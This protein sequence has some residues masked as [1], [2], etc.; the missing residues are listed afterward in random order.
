V[1]IA[2]YGF[3][4]YD[5]AA[6]SGTP[7]LFPPCLMPAKSYLICSAVGD[8]AQFSSH[9]R[10]IGLAHF[11]SLNNS[12]DELSLLDNH[13]QLLDRVA[14]QSSWYGKESSKGRSLERIDV[15]TICS[16]D[17]NWLPSKDSMGTT[18]GRVN[19]VEGE[20]VDDRP[21]KAKRVSYLNDSTL[22]LELNKSV[23]L[24]ALNNASFD[25]APSSLLPLSFHAANAAQTYWRIQ[26]PFMM[27]ADSIYY[28]HIKALKDCP[29]REIEAVRMPFG[30]PA[31]PAPG[32]L[33]LNEI[34]FNPYSGSSDFVELLN[35]SNRILDLSEVQ[36]QEISVED[37]SLLGAAYLGDSLLQCLPG[38]YLACTEQVAAVLAHYTV[39][40]T[41]TLHE[42]PGLPNYD[43]LED[44]VALVYRRVLLDELHY[45]HHWH[46]ALLN[47]EDGVSL[48]RLD[49][50]GVTQSAA[51]WHSAASANGYAT[52][53]YRNSQYNPGMNAT[54]NLTVE[55]AIFSPDQDGRDD[56]LQI[57]YQNASAGS[58]LNLSI[59]D[60]NGQLIKRIAH[61]DIGATEGLYTWDGLNDQGS[62]AAVGPYLLAADFLD[63]NGKKFQIR[64]KVILAQK[65]R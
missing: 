27:D 28:L 49:P 45:D 40:D 42:V 65:L 20:F 51:N 32:D 4:L 31:L 48:E 63:L 41:G 44:I 29:G 58:L 13:A 22:M 38:E 26:L 57:R 3:G 15:N 36:L 5:A 2:L 53:G 16:T 64:K 37:S 61:N 12:G 19:S 34:L 6:W 56:I 21:F 17:A 1:P 59:Y 62:L 10:V 8:T 50:A 25:I 54:S 14:Y 52:P 47:D 30:K 11:P 18:P 60:L 55:P 9:G 39:A 23:S 46:F 33:V 35:R 43:D 24:S 7:A